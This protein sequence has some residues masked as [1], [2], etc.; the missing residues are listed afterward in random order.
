MNNE[1][2]TRNQMSFAAFATK[3]NTLS[4]TAG[5]TK[6][7]TNC[8]I[9]ETTTSPVVVYITKPAM[10][11]LQSLKERT[12]DT[13]NQKLQVA[14]IQA[15]NGNWIVAVCNKGN[16]GLQNAITVRV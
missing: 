7:G 2:V 8:A 16:G 1:L 15:N 13:L 14:E 6:R 11:T 3:I 9:F 5:Q 4:F 12:M 10:E